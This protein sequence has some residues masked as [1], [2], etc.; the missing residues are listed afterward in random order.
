MTTLAIYGDRRSGNCHKVVMT[1]R[2]TGRPYEWVET[3]IMNGESRTAA[4]LALN[5]A[6]QVPTVRLEDGRALAQSNAII[7]HLGENTPLVPGDAFARAKMYEWLFWEQYSHEPYVATPRFQKLLLG[8]MPD[9]WRMDRGEAAL[10][11]MNSHLRDRDF[12]VGDR[13]SLADVALVAYTR[14]AGDAG[15]DL[16]QRPAVQEWTKRV[17]GLLPDWPE[18]FA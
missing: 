7:L 9:P 3:D 12:F 14:L 1:C 13:P 5:P 18:G 8:R 4:F 17:M 10:D 2:L 16:G 11:H 15:F 6:G